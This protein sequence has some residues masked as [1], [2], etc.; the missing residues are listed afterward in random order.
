MVDSEIGED[1]QQDKQYLKRLAE[2]VQVFHN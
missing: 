2:G 1:T